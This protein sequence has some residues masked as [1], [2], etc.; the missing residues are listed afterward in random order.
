M[1]KASKWLENAVSRIRFHGLEISRNET[2]IL[3]ILIEIETRKEYSAAGFESLF[4]FCVKE[5]GWS[6]S[7]TSTRTQAMFAMQAVPAL[8]EKIDAGSMTI[9]TVAQVQ[10]LIRQEQVE[11]GVHRTPDEKLELFN[12]FEG[13]T[14]AEVKEQI[15]VHNGERIKR[16]ISVELDEEAEQLWTEVC[17]RSAHQTQGSALNCLKLLMRAYLQEP[18]MKPKPRRTSSFLKKQTSADSKAKSEEPKPKHPVKSARDQASG[19]EVRASEE[20]RDSTSTA[21]SGPPSAS[22]SP[23]HASWRYIPISTRRIVFARARNQCQ[24]CGSKHALQIDHILPLAKGG[25]HEP[26]NLQV[27]CR[28]CNLQRAVKH[29]GAEKVRR[30]PARLH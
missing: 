11:A 6:E 26:E 22:D 14:A 12:T 20:I 3:E 13:K 8:K 23:L 21:T 30:E 25:T 7:E 4:K 1:K 16:K 2:A 17:N 9:T 27:L 10:R 15:A 18:S 5:I 19:L 29:F 24:N 28:N